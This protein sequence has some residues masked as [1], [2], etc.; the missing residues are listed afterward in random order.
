MEAPIT[1]TQCELLS[2]SPEVHSQV[3][4]STTMCRIPNTEAITSQKLVCVEEEDKLP[5]MPRFAVQHAHHHT[6][7]DGTLIIPDPIEAYYKSLG[8]GET[9]DPNKLK[10]AATSAAIRSIYTLVDNSQQ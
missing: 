8:S 1:I 9:P 6:P 3:R 4:D 5:P 10:I 7:P 2:L